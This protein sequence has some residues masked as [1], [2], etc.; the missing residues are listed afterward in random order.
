MYR[1]VI[2]AMARYR[3]MQPSDADDL[4]Q[5]VFVAVSTAIERFDP[6]REDAKFRTWI[7]TIARRAIIN[8]LTTRDRKSLTVN[9]DNMEWLLDPHTD[10]EDSTRELQLAYRRQVFQVAATNVQTQFDP[11]TWLAFWRTAVQ[12]HAPQQ[13]AKELDRSV[14]SVYTAR[15]RVIAKLRYWV[16]ELDISKGET[17]DV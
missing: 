2:V 6:D 1:D 12:G 3:G 15:S 14:G 5:V 8:A 7:K 10:D 16:S 9:G 13:V 11:S 4:A 17:N